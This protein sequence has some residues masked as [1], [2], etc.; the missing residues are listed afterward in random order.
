MQCTNNLKQIG[1]AVHN[2]ADAHQKMPPLSKLGSFVD[3]LPYLEQDQIFRQIAQNENDEE[4]K[5][6]FLAM[7]L[8]VFTCPSSTSDRGTCYQFSAGSGSSINAT[9]AMTDGIFSIGKPTQFRDITDGTSQTLMAVESPSGSELPRLRQQL[10]YAK[11][12]GKVPDDVPNNNAGAAAF[13]EGVN[14]A[15]DRGHNWMSPTFLQTLTVVRLAPITRCLMR[16]TKRVQ[17]ERLAHAACTLASRTCYWVTVA[18]A[19]LLITRKNRSFAAWRQKPVVRSFK[20]TEP[21]FNNWSIGPIVRPSETSKP[22]LKQL[23]LGQLLVQG[24]E[25]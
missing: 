16:C 2:F 13:A 24:Q 22:V 21:P 12:T 11:L 4:M 14:L 3:L 18:S 6:R 8:P 17:A 9:N 5:K 20:L 1:L 23:V 10:A 7:R 15:F 25:T 19:R